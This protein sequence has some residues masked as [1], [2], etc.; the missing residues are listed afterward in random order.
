M[1]ILSNP[2]THTQFVD[3]KN[4]AS[5]M[6]E[7]AFAL[8]FTS[9]GF[10][11]HASQ[12]FDPKYALSADAEDA[13]ISEIERLKNAYAGRM[14]IWR[15]IERDRVS[16][17]DRTKYEYI[18]AANHYLVAENGDYTA[19]DSDAASVE[20]FV[21]THFGG[22]W[23]RA[24]ETY[25]SEY[26]EYVER[27]KPDIIAHFDIIAKSNRAAKWF[28]ESGSDYINAGNAALG[29]MIRACGVLEVNT[30]G[31]ARSGQTVPYPI[32]TFLKTWRDLGGSVIPSSDCHRAHQ[33]DAWF[34]CV[35]EYIESCGFDSCLRLGSGDK[36]FERV[37][38]AH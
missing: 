9:L 5:E 11:E 38:F 14:R 17:A 16:T 34:E 37:S 4:T 33:L 13:Y 10:T 3:G 19:V 36:L 1:K 21:F 28:F 7:R 24:F 23:R 20:K 26:A 35:Y 6:A 22:D 12:P 30:G 31:I 25:F 18:L 27:E 8:G 15:G 2:H 29:R 32:K